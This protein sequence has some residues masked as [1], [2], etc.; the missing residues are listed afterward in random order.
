MNCKCGHI[1]PEGKLVCS[2]CFKVGKEKYEG[3]DTEVPTAESSNKQ[4]LWW[5][6]ERLIYVYGE[7][8]NVDFVQRVKAMSGRT[9]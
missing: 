1:L 2:S 5:L 6:Y 9:E 7:S 8:E 4:F 3:W